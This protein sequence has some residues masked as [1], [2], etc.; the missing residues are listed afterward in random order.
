MNK[1]KSLI[2]CVCLFCIAINVFA[3]DT[4]VLR[5][6]DFIN[7]IVTE[8]S[9]NQVKYKKAS[10]PDGP[11]YIID[12]SDVLSIKYTN[13]DVDKFEKS[14]SKSDINP[15]Q[16]TVVEATPAEDNEEDKAK[17]S[18]LPKLNLKKSNKKSKG[19]FPIM[20][21]TDSSVISTKEI[22]VIIN[23]EAVEYYDGGW[24]VKIGYT[25]MILN[26][27]DDPIYIDR[28]N[29]FRR[30]CDFDTKSYFDNIQTTVTHGNSST[31]GVGIGNGHFGVGLGSS[32]NS[33]HTESYGVDRILVIGPHSKAN[34]VDY[35]YIRL[36]EKKAKFKTISDIEYWGFN[37]PGKS[38]INQGEVQTYT[39]NNTPY[40]NRYY[41]TYSTDQQFQQC[42]KFN[43]ELFAKYI[44]GAEMKQSK[45]SNLNPTNNIVKE[46]QKT[47]PDF[48]TN[49]LSIIGMMGEFID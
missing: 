14:S 17:Y 15:P 24:K 10:N 20:A 25:I 3:D 19:F 16:N 47:I 18:A 11:I 8:V 43:F 21:F 46:Y 48:W 37:L 4:I 41:I 22:S 12:V 44:V 35:K 36:S 38:D 9:A 45:W 31:S 5:N 2:F 23:P 13:G 33:S 49:S 40:S 26:K 29:C 39:E 27:T 1:K 30:Y 42:Y 28:A 7:A 34:L 6:G 32:S